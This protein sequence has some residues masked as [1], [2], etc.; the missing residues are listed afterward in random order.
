MLGR[1]L[2]AQTLNDIMKRFDWLLI[3]PQSTTKILSLH[4]FLLH[5]QVNTN[6]K[7][8][9]ASVLSLFQIGI[10]MPYMF[11]MFV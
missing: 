11:W 9:L 1:S 7:I 5:L 3:Q 10:P 4:L 2:V 8:R 6:I